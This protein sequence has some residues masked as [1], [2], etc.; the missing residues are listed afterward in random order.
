[1]SKHSEGAAILTRAFKHL[2]NRDSQQDTNDARALLVSVMD[3][4]IDA[5]YKEA[6]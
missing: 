1:M 5:M 2:R 3:L 4:V 6:A